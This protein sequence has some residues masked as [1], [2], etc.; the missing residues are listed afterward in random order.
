LFYSVEELCDF[1][2]VSG[3]CGRFGSFRA[4][5]TWCLVWFLRSILP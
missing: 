3:W 1:S 2:C 4:F 5:R